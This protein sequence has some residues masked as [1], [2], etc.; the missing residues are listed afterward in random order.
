M[1]PVN[2]VIVVDCDNTL[3][4]GV[5]AEDGIENIIIDGPSQS[6]QNFLK[7][8][9][10]QGM[11]LCLCSKNELLDI[12]NVF[13]TRKDMI[14]KEDDITLWQV[15]WRAKEK[16]IREISDK[17]QLQLNS[18]IFIDD[19]IIE[20]QLIQYTLPEVSVI[21]LSDEI[22]SMDNFF[23]NCWQFDRLGLTEEDLKRSKM[24]KDE[25]VQKK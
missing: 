21:H 17:L 13:Y 8:Q 18:F 25:I 5:V 11:L 1:K 3:W 9:V 2:K 24:Y 23:K 6:L 7:T 15:N 12:Q 19:N 20:C 16:N 14:L 4:Q 22:K 10:E